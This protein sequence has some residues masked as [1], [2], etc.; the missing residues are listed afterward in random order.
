MQIMVTFIDKE[1]RI[2]LLI[3]NRQKIIDTMQTVKETG[4][5]FT[6]GEDENYYVKSLRKCR[7]ISV[8][9]SYEEAGIFSGDVLE[10]CSC[11]I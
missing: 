5:L 1:T 2:D 11:D 7:R 4:W 8:F 10:A 6:D 9:C 3:D